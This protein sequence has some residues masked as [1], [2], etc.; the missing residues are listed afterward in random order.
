MA[1]L[2]PEAIRERRHKSAL[3]G[4]FRS[5]FRAIVPALSAFLRNG[6]LVEAGIVDPGPIAEYLERPNLW[7]GYNITRLLE[8]AAAEQWLRSFD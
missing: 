2:L 8:I 1:D 4:M 7:A 3:G 5:R 6:R